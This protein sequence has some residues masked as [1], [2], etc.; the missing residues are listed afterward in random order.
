[1]VAGVKSWGQS[2]E[3][4][5]KLEKM[6][7]DLG[8]WR[9]SGRLRRTQEAGDRLKK[10]ERDLGRCRQTQE[11]GERLRKLEQTFR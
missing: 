8:S 11:D 6:E 3:G 5:N 9:D 10:L 2:W 1:M 4:E 7:T